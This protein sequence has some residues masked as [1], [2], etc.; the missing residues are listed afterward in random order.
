MYNIYLHLVQIISRAN[1][2]KA[3]DNSP[4]QMINSPYVLVS[5]TGLA[6]SGLCEHEALPAAGQCVLF[7][8]A[9]KPYS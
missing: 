9:A 7:H 2:N 3:K 8:F 1:T 4:A 6:Y 5:D